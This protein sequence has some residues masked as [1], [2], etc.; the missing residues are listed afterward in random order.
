MNEDRKRRRLVRPED[1][2]RDA[3]LVAADD[4]EAATLDDEERLTVKDGVAEN[5]R[6]LER[7]RRQPN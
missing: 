2:D 1:L 4:T 6:R 5:K 7:Q 3:S